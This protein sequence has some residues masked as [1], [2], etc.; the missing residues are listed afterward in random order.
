MKTREQRERELLSDGFVDAIKQQ[1]VGKNCNIP[2]KYYLLIAD[3]I[4]S[5]SQVENDL[6]VDPVM[7]AK[8][9]PDVLKEV[10]DDNLQGIH[11]ITDNKTIR[12]N[13]SMDYETNKLYFFHELTHAIQTR[14]IDNKEICAFSDGK[15]GMFLTEG[16]TQFTAEI[17]YH[18][19]NETNLQYRNQPNTVRGHSEHTPYSALS[20][21]QL[22]G[23]VLMLLGASL[24]LELKDL[25]AM[26]Y[27]SD[28]RQMLKEMY[29]VFPENQGKFEEFMFDLEK[30]YSIDKC[31]IA[32]Y[33]SQLNGEPVNIQMNG[34]Q[35]FQGNIQSQ[36]ELI[37]KVERELAANFIGFNETDYIL[38]HWEL[39][40]NSLTTSQLKSEFIN[41]INE[42]ATMQNTNI[43]ST[44][45]GR[46]R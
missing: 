24:G 9:I 36:G 16:S 18:I 46:S 43:Q 20:E 4:D 33:G 45:S 12:M 8:M 34:G 44:G 29:E 37:N 32:G 21:Y 30:I 25:L 11:G 41:A 19:S 15:T 17:L 10:R 6:H 3:Y 28:G 38:S 5:L 26:A 35:Q 39:V 22:N 2:E 14:I 1:F 27:R 13:N 40:Y 23:N 31:L 42:I 7:I